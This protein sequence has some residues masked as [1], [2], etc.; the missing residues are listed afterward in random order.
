MGDDRS[1]V[2]LVF[3]VDAN[4]I[5][6]GN[7]VVGCDQVTQPSDDKSAAGADGYSDLLETGV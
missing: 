5:T 3:P 7:H 2:H 1:L 6:S 4:L